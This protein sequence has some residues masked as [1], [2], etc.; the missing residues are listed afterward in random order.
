[1]MA[2]KST[3]IPAKITIRW[4]EDH[5]AC[6]DQVALFGRIF[7]ADGGELTPENIVAAARAGLDL[8]WFAKE[9]LAAPALAEYERVTDQAL[10]EYERVTTSA[11]AEYQRVAAPAWAEYERVKAQAWAEYQRVTA[12]A[13][14]EY[15]RVTASALIAAL[16]PA[17]EESRDE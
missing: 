14:A 7:G 2:M 13:L 16:W 9:V 3:K 11:L 12:P 4:L 6:S 5:G 8:D 10:A 17:Q 15:Q 1:M